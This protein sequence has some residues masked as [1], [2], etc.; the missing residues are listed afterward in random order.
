MSGRECSPTESRSDCNDAPDAPLTWAQRLKRVFEIDAVG[1]PTKYSEKLAASIC[2]RLLHAESLRSIC[3][4]PD[5]PS[6]TTVCNWLGK[7]NHPFVEQYAR[8]RRIQAELLADEI[9]EIADDGRNDFMERQRENGEVSLQADRENVQRSKLRLDARKWVA[10]RL[11]PKKYG[12]R[13]Q[14]DHVVEAKAEVQIRADMTP[15]E[16]SRIYRE[17]IKRPFD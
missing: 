14:L 1:R 7:Q 10:A 3:K 4:S 2:E 11:L 16:A 9:I 6:L 13:Q 12:D 17:N 5:L 8:A 15:E